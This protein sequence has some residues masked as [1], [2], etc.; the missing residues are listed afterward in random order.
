[1]TITSPVITIQ[2]RAYDEVLE[3]F[4]Q[5]TAVKPQV[6]RY[7]EVMEPYRRIGPMTWRSCWPCWSRR[8]VGW[9]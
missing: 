4:N 5:Q 8:R 9:A 6:K 2:V 1:M 3:P 7:D